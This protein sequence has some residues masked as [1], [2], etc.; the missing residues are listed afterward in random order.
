MRGNLKTRMFFMSICLKVRSPFIP[1]STMKGRIIP[2]SGTAFAARAS[3]ALFGFAR[4]CLMSELDD[5]QSAVDKIIEKIYSRE[6][7]AV[8]AALKL[9]DETRRDVIA[10][11]A[12][13]GSE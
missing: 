12:E 10:R 6:Q 3:S 8:D 11:I 13:S 4:E 9:L 1:S 5:F 2:V 7:S